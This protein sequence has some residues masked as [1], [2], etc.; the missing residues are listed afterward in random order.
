MMKTSLSTKISIVLGTIICSVLL[1]YSQ[2][3]ATGFKLIHTPF[4]ID[5][6][7]FV[8]GDS[9]LVSGNNSNNY[10][11][12][13]IDKRLSMKEIPGVP[14]G[15]IRPFLFKGRP[16]GLIDNFGDE[17]YLSTDQELNEILGFRKIRSIFSFNNGSVIIVQFRRDTNVYYYD[18]TKSD[19]TTLLT[20]VNRVHSICLS[21]D[22]SFMVIDYDGSLEIIS[23]SERDQVVLAGNSAGQA[24]SPTWLALRFIFQ[25]IQI[26]NFTSY[27]K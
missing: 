3:R 4:E 14:T 10:R 23:L 22:K 11:L 9:I 25:I 16:V 5:P 20:G 2:Q 26:L 19:L 24:M 7:F 8:D 17:D 21:E 1:Y 18:I 6:N 27:I 15:S 13:S 12:Y